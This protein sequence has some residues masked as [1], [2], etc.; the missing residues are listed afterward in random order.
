MVSE[1]ILS[2]NMSVLRIEQQ[3]TVII[4]TVNVSKA[5][6]Q[7]KKFADCKVVKRARNISFQT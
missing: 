3:E 6:I 1:D 7:W 4:F 2:F 5:I